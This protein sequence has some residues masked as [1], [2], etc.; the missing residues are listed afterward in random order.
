MNK[1]ESRVYF[2]HRLN[3]SV[4]DEVLHN[5]RIGT[6]LLVCSLEIW[7]FLTKY[8]NTDSIFHSGK[9]SADNKC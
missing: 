2:S 4:Q 9:I 5:G 1:F 6:L 8:G 7:K 3:H